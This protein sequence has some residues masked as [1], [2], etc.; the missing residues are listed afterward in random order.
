MGQLTP[1]QIAAWRDITLVLIEAGKQAVMTVRSWFGVVHPEMTPEQL[2]AAWQQVLDEDRIRLAI[3][4]AA[5]AGVTDAG[6]TVGDN[7]DD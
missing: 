2:E 3:S 1:E 4:L 5:S 7:N 6:A